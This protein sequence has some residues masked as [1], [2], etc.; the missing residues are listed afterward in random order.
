[1]EFEAFKRTMLMLALSTIGATALIFVLSYVSLETV[2]TVLMFGVLA[3]IAYLLY[4]VNLMQVKAEK[5]SKEYDA[6]K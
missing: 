2:L 5:E 4:A 3:W 6:K 1:M